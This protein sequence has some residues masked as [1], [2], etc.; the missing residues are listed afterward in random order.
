MA[1][2]RS[3]KWRTWCKQTENQVSWSTISHKWFET[4][5]RK[6]PLKKTETMA[7]CWM[8]RINHIKLLADWW[9]LENMKVTW[10][11][12][13][14][15]SQAR[16]WGTLSKLQ[17]GAS[18]VCNTEEPG[19]SRAHTNDTHGLQHLEQEVSA[20]VVQRKYTLPAVR[21][22]WHESSVFKNRLL[23]HSFQVVELK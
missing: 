9:S 23:D 13:S 15:Q 5:A 14:S 12:A 11:Q 1:N 20:S 10:R 21:A 16:T 17:T 19:Y 4:T 3:L 7:A 2:K 18:S 6:I 22:P 8:N